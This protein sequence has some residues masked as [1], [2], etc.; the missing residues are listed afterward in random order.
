L[1]IQYETPD[2]G[3]KTCPKYVE[4]YSKNKFEKLVHLAGF[5]IRIYHDAKFS[6]FQKNLLLPSLFL[7]LSLVGEIALKGFAFEGLC[8]RLAS[9]TEHFIKACCNA[10]ELQLSESWLSESPISQIGLAL[11]VNLSRILQN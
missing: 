3:K 5:I 2:D 9:C 8:N 6:E 7:L 4:F 10:L 1:C 11:R